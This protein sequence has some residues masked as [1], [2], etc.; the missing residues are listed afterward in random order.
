MF[1]T[2][3]SIRAGKPR[4]NFGKLGGPDVRCIVLCQMAEL[5]HGTW[6]GVSGAPLIRYSR[7][8]TVANTT[9]FLWNAT[10]KLKQIVNCC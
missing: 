4:Q 6:L 9:E 8:A 2:G 3:L 10:S 7:V 1:S 5:S